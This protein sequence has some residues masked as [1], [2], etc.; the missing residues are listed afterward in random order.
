[1]KPWGPFPAPERKVN[2]TF[3]H[4]SAF[5][6]PTEP[7]TDVANIPGALLRAGHCEVLADAS[8]K[9]DSDTILR[10]MACSLGP[11]SSSSRSWSTDHQTLRTPAS[12]L[13]G[14]FSFAG[15]CLFLP[16]LG[17]CWPVCWDNRGG[18]QGSEH[19]QSRKLTVQASGGGWP[20]N[21]GVSSSGIGCVL[22][23]WSRP[24][25]RKSVF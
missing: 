12:C 9:L 17:G 20:W 19:H 22:V 16:V 25:N 8:R 10:Q 3:S 11:S 14:D 21:R 18:L 24:H 23:I 1:M 5:H 6:S 4:L 7:F 2:T 15:S 13:G